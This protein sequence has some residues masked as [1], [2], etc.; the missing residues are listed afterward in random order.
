MSL[1]TAAPERTPLT[2]PAVEQSRLPAPATST[3]LSLTGL[4]LTGLPCH[5][6]DP[7][8]WFS[9]DVDQIAAA[10]R[11]C[12]DCAFRSACLAGAVARAEPWGVWGG[13]LFDGGTIVAQ[14]RAKGR[15]RKDAVATEQAA[16]AALLA[17]LTELGLTE[18]LDSP[19]DDD[20]A[21]A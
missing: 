16:Q 15:P 11:L 21:A 9:E 5:Q 6:G 7:D 18:L 2:A 8:L 12:E 10:Q 17:R 20:G 19:R 1:P 13:E 14:K 3:A 4:P